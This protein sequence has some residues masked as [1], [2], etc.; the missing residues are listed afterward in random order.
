M[1][2]GFQQTV[3]Q[4]QAPAVAGDFCSTN[5]RSSVLTVPGGFV[6]G[7]AGVTVG[8]FAWVDYDATDRLVNNFGIGAPTGFVHREQQGLITTYLAQTSN[9]VPGGFPV[10]LFDAGDFWVLNSGSNAVTRGMKAY[11]NYANG[12]VTFAATGAPATG[13]SVT[14]S[15]AAN[16]T[17]TFTASIA[18][19]VM[20]VTAQAAGTIIVGMGISGSGITSGTRVT[21]QLT[22][23]AGGV[24]T[25]L[26]SII[27]TATS[28]TVTGAYGVM[29]VTAVGS[30]ALNIGD[31]LSGASVTAGNTVIGLGTG[32]GGTGTYYVSV[33][34]T[35][36]ST[37]ITATGNIETKWIAASAAAPGELVKMSSTLLG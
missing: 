20:T 17:S 36:S 9:L 3:N 18:E 8:T 29:T 2:L 19:Q 32:T 37:T 27:Q 26:V 28:T 5:P 6:A 16:A 12:L 4:N 13:A 35:A 14:G 21:K 31:I 7:A 1:T 34:D 23:T 33:G 11:A 22:G 30:G 24:G 15:I 25:Y 10:T